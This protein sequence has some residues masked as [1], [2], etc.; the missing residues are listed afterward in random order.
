MPKV[1]NFF[2]VGA[3]KAGTTS[4]YHY[5]DQHPAIYMSPVKE[6]NHFASE[7]RL[8]GF[9]E[10]QQERVRHGMEET[11]AYLGGVMREKRFGAV[12]LDWNDYLKLFR[13]ADGEKALGEASVCYLWSQSAARNIFAR[14]PEAK[15][16]MILRDP[17]ERAFSQYMQWT[18]KGGMR[19]TFLE[20][21]EKSIANA[22]G[23]FR[24]MSPFL[25]MG[26]YANQVRRYLDLF[27]RENIHIAFYE[28]YER[29]PKGILADLLR[30]L[31]VDETFRPD[32]SRR[33]L[34][35]NGGG[36]VMSD[37]ER[38]YLTDY[39]REDLRML[40]RLLNRDLSRWQA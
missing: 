29:N 11:R 39:Y 17:A 40:S 2:I 14:V 34:V 15:I 32:M 19:D 4:L 27:P 18:S 23:K 26:L 37:A 30:F 36:R 21:C 22:G 7:I 13:N 20:A 28:D 25:E 1:P 6:P 16:V 38:R 31:G 5:L 10:A 12:G 35:G 8:E 3:P 33:Y 9:A 24:P